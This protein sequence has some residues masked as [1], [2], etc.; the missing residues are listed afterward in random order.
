MSW[1]TRWKLSQ[2]LLEVFTTPA[3]VIDEQLSAMRKEVDAIDEDMVSQWMDKLVLKYPELLPSLVHERD[4][5]LAWSL[6]RSK[7]VNG[8]KR[9]V[10]VVGRGHMRGIM[11]ALKHDPGNLRFR[12]L[13]GG[14]NRKSNSSKKGSSA[15]VAAR[16]IF[17]IASAYACYFAWTKFTQ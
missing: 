15:Q 9:V 4:M 17:E 10:G 7:A 3:S 12:D 14:K 1:D 2:V 6:K 13:V 5:Y 8:T 16:I 11:H